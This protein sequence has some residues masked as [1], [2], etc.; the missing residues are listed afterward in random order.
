VESYYITGGMLLPNY[1]QM[2]WKGLTLV[3]GKWRYIDPTA[4]VIRPSTYRHWG[5]DQNGKVAPN[6]N[7]TCVAAASDQTYELAWGWDDVTCDQQYVYICKQM[8]KWHPG[9]CLG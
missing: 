3:A 6:S 8:R 5:T 1:N 4:P 9:Q 7:G 2:Y